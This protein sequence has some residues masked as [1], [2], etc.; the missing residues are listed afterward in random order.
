MKE[1]MQGR[2]GF[3]KGAGVVAA[4][5][6]MMLAGCAP[7]GQNEVLA[8][9]ASAAENITWDG[10]YDIIAAGAGFAGLAV[11]ATVA[12]EGNGA[13]CLL[14][15]KDAK[16]NGNSPLCFGGI[17]CCDSL[18]DARKFMRTMLDESVSDEICDVFAEGVCENQGWLKALGA[19]DEDLA[20]PMPMH[21]QPDLEGTDVCYVQLFN[22][23]GTGFTHGHVFLTDYV[24]KH[25]DVIDFKKNTPLESLVQDPQTGAILGVVADGKRYKANKGVVMCTGGF[26]SDSEMM[27]QFTG[28]RGAKPLAAQANTGDGH[29]ACMA[30]GADMWHMTSGAQFFMALRNLENSEFVSR[31]FNYAPK[32]WGIT[33][34]TNGRRYYNDFDGC[35]KFKANPDVPFGDSRL[36]VGYRHG[37]TQFGGEWTHLPFPSTSWFIFDQAAYEEGN[38]L[39]DY[40]IEDPVAEGWMVQAD[41]IEEL[42]GK[43][44]V[45]VEELTRTIEVWNNYCDKGHDDSFYRPSDT[46]TPIR[47]APFSAMLCAPTLLNT[48]GG[49]VRN[50]KAQILDTAGNPIPNLYSAGEFGSVWGHYYQGGGNVGECLVFGRIAAREALSAQA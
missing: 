9:T 33:V 31:A 20:D 45:P 2:R 30:V 39:A 50:E 47:T 13:T 29:R 22:S 17:M 44:D 1:I 34:G 25:S 4:A 8:S 37:L 5:S 16:A 36:S 46:L 19:V 26:E 10:E 38:F 43:I 35:S 11:A 28:V 3:L 18:D 42:A 6:A 27:A 48:D 24:E 49:P 14:L 21:E 12:D 23:K 41:T 40:G 32:E 15:E 7:K